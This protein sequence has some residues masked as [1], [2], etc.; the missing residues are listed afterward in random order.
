M[1]G[2]GYES[3]IDYAML[4]DAANITERCA[5]RAVG[6]NTQLDLDVECAQFYLAEQMF[7][8]LHSWD[9]DER[10]PRGMYSQYH[11]RGNRL[12]RVADAV[13]KTF[14]S[15]A[16]YLAD[17]IALYSVLACGGELRYLAPMTLRSCYV[18]PI[19][20]EEQEVICPSDMEVAWAYSPEILT[21]TNAMRKRDGAYQ[22]SD[23]WAG[24]Y[25][26]NYI[27]MVTD[28]YGS[29]KPSRSAGWGSWSLAAPP[30]EWGTLME[31]C[32][33][34]FESP[35]WVYY[36]CL[37]AHGETGSSIMYVLVSEDTGE[38][39][40]I[41]MD[42]KNANTSVLERARRI[43][44]GAPD[45]S[46]TGVGG[47][48]WAV[49]ARFTSLYLTGQMSSYVYLDRM[50]SVQHNG[51]SLFNKLFPVNNLEVVLSQQYQN[52]YRWLAGYIQRESETAV[53]K[54]LLDLW[55]DFRYEPGGEWPIER[56]MPASVADESSDYCDYC[57][58]TGDYCYNGPGPNPDCGY[59]PEEE[60]YEDY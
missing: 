8:E 29:V 19:T 9:G 16:E 4:D 42:D 34:A 54:Y 7:S 22:V 49:P 26:E 37:D 53:G 44:A 21:V 17:Q 36:T 1:I 15:R 20:R 45:A 41:Q 38:L 12:E 60:D 5:A 31:Q 10:K 47:K 35:I 25:V 23:F 27:T 13:R 3:K 11:G 56:L 18:I 14:L 33:K 28:I 52:N 6:I 2:A 58:H 57:E 59:A 30:A 40:S 39:V 48:N 51:G 24:D 43:L 46:N 50:W 32:A 55:L